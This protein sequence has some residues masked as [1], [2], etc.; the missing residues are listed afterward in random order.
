MDVREEDELIKHAIILSFYFLL[1]LQEGGTYEMAIRETIQL[2]GDTDTNAAIVGGLMGAA[3]GF[4]KIPEAMRT[5]VLEFDCA[6]N[7][8]L[9]KTRQ[10]P[11]IL[12]V[13]LKFEEKVKALIQL[14]PKNS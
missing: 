4:D 6:G 3:V 12:S 5:K 14:R 10:R 13:K 8:L 2:G 7:D 11:E 1:R 9:S